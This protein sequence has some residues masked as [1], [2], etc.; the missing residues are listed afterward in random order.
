MTVQSAGVVSRRGESG[1]GLCYTPRIPEAEAVEERAPEVCA[2][3]V[4]APT[5]ADLRCVLV[6]SERIDPS[7]SHHVKMTILAPVWPLH[8]HR[9]F[10]QH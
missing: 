4:A 9:E 1:F 3:D 6:A 8:I 5:V 10:I 2:V 7:H